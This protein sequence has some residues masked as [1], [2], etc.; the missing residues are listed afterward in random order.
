MLQLSTLN[1]PPLFYFFSFSD[2]STLILPCSIIHTNFNVDQ[3]LQ[4]EE[5][6]RSISIFLHVIMCNNVFFFLLGSLKKLSISSS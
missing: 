4:N 5:S 2:T 6:A 3:L 1:A